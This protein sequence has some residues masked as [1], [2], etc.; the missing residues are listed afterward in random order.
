M[1]TDTFTRQELA[2]QISSLK[3]GVDPYIEDSIFYIPKPPRTKKDKHPKNRRN[4]YHQKRQYKFAE[5]RFSRGSLVIVCREKADGSKEY[6]LQRD[7]NDKPK[8]PWDVLKSR[9]GFVIG[10][11]LTEKELDETAAL[12]E[13]EEE[14]LIPINVGTIQYV[15][16]IP[17]KSDYNIHVFV[18]YVPVGT[19]DGQGD[20]VYSY[21]WY[22]KEEIQD[23]VNKGLILP[24]HATAWNMAVAKGLV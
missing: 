9:P 14:T 18:K 17:V 23:M 6:R 20:Q 5:K 13:T 15:D 22:D 8:G 19:E 1:H 24:N 4:R 10:S 2:D 3:S 7:F 16:K 11:P 21:D 12:R